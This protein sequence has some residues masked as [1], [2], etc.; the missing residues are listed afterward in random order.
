M[1]GVFCPLA[2]W[3]RTSGPAL[4]V[5]CRP[6]FI[7]SQGFFFLSKRRIT[8]QLPVPGGKAWPGLAIACLD[9]PQLPCICVEWRTA[10]PPQCGAQCE[11]PAASPELVQEGGASLAVHHTQQC[12]LCN[13]NDF[14]LKFI[15]PKGLV[16]AP[17]LWALA[18]RN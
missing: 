7:S 13:R 9:A 3:Q 11:H 8:N 12:A 2:F 17:T 15:A 1:R 16:Y 5:L 18:S 14:M 10:P 6:S 4:H